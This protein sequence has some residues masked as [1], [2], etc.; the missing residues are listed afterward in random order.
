M[1]KTLLKFDSVQKRLI[2]SLF[3]AIILSIS[4]FMYL[5][6]QTTVNAAMGENLE[7]NMGILR[8]EVGDLAFRYM[9]M[10]G[11]VTLDYAY[12]LGFQEAPSIN[13]VSRGDALSRSL[14]YKAPENN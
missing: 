14:S 10:K 2:V 3:F 11:V 13:F 12:S 9:E 5:L 4:L 7:S 6:V 8:T 1:V